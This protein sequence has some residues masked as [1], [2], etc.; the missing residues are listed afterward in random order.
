MAHMGFSLLTA[1]TVAAASWLLFW[2]MEPRAA[3]WAGLQ[4]GGI[5]PKTL[6]AP[7]LLWPREGPDHIALPF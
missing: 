4:A 1:E 5:I 2:G 7:H 3:C 6:P